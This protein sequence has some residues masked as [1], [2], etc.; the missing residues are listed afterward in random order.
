MKSNHFGKCSHLKFLY[1]IG[2]NNISWRPHNP[3]PKIRG[4]DPS[5][6][7]ID[8]YVAV[9]TSDRGKTGNT[10]DTSNKDDIKA[11]YTCRYESASD[12]K[13]QTGKKDMHLYRQQEANAFFLIKATC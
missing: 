7:R 12:N 8:A 6:P 10:G 2:Y 1:I 5:N 11:G 3:H 13:R 4:C 9:N